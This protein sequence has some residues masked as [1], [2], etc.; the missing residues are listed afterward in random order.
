MNDK[1]TPLSARD[2]EAWDGPSSGV[3]CSFRF[4]GTGPHA[5]AEPRLAPDGRSGWVWTHVRLGD[6]RAIALL[7]GLPGLPPEALELFVS[8]ETRIQIT[9]EAGWVF[10][11]LPDLERDFSGHP[12]D[13][14]RLA[15]AL[16]GDR[17]LTGRLHPLL[18]VD[19]LRRASEAGRSFSEPFGA[20]VAHAQFYIDRIEEVLDDLAQQMAGIEDYV[21]T[22]PQN[23]RDTG[24]SGLRRKIARRRRDL[25]AL[26]G[27]LARALVRGRLGKRARGFSEELAELIAA[28]EDAERE[29]GVLQERGRLLHEEIDTLINSATNRSMRALTI[30]STL[31]IP[32]TLVTGAFGMNLKGIPF[33]DSPGGFAAAAVICAMVVGG[34]LLMLRRLGM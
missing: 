24:L 28:V 13:S 27:A 8:G 23:P 32:P 30:V 1:P 21:L 2:F 3:I 6:V 17:L 5:L 33:A 9:E 16:E 26:R 4:D 10:G 12:Q 11:V 14:G 29:T 25:Q 22:E 20:I 34:A 7:R 31:L 18:A 15:F 19:D